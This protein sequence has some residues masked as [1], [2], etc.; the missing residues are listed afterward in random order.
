M[1]L[2]S[3]QGQEVR[4][5]TLIDADW[6]FFQGDDPKAKEAAFD[7]ASWRKLNVPHDW[8]IEGTVDQ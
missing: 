1:A 3:L 6:K 4:K 5:E 2:S 7:D 8:S